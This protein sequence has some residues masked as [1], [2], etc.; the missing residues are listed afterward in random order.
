[1]TSIYQFDNYKKFFNSW[2]E[3]QPKKG[4]G[5]Y[6]RLALHLNVSTTQTALGREKSNTG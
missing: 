2:I 6:R 1:M 4:H 5:E 3:N